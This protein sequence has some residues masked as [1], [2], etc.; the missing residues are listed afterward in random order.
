MKGTN[1]TYAPGNGAKGASCSQ[2]VQN[3]KKNFPASA[4]SCASSGQTCKQTGVFTN[5]QGRSFSG[6][7]KQ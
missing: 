7:R 3:C 5:P 4:G 1:P 2:A 6:L